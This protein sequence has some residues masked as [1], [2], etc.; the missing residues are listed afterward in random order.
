MIEAWRDIKFAKASYPSGTPA[1]L[2]LDE[3]STVSLLADWGG[4][5]PAAKR[6][7]ATAANADP[8]PKT[9]I[10]LGDIYYGGIKAECE[11]LPTEL[12]TSD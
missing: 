1:T 11:G 3:H 2:P 9:V 4:D 5:N 7:A 8:K 12:A 10:H 6:V